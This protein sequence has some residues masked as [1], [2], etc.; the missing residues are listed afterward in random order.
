MLPEVFESEDKLRELWS[1]PSTRKVLLKNLEIYGFG[2]DD[3]IEIQKIIDAEKSDIFD[4]LEF[5]A[6]AK[7]PLTRSE[8][9]ENTEEIMKKAFSNDQMEFV[10]FVLSQY[11]DEGVFVLDDEKLPILLELKYKSIEN[12]KQLLG[13]LDET[14]N[15]FLNFQK[16]LYKV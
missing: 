12:A 13:N 16:A 7:K 4:V 10:N 14:R 9:I 15:L 6:F 5:V 11:V 8:R 3:L 2:L 1:V